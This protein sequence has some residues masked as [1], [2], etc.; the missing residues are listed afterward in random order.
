MKKEVYDSKLNKLSNLSV[1]SKGVLI[2]TNYNESGKEVEFPINMVG[3]IT[4]AS[5]ISKYPERGMYLGYKSEY[6]NPKK[7]W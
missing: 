5:L 4:S 6:E 7:G 1:N 2:E 3:E